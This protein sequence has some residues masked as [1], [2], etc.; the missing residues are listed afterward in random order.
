M[1]NSTII[2][3]KHGHKGR[4]YI[5]S[6]YVSWTCMIQRCYNDKN[7][8]YKS[9]KGKGI[10]VCE[11]W[12]NS[13]IDFLNDMGF[14]PTKKHRLDRIDSNGNYEPGNCRWAT[15]V[16]QNKNNCA[17]RR[18]EYNGEIKLHSEWS[19]ELGITQSLFNYH[20]KNK[21]LEQIFNFYKNKK[22]CQ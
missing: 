12:K 13:F 3:I 11:K 18:I 9:Y 7:I 1:R 21:T 16:E 4:K 20:L 19:K 17:N 8:S 15:R 22:K 10:K 6:E 14:K 5:S 2:N